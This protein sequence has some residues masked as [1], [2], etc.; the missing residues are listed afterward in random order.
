MLIWMWRK[1][2]LVDS[3][4]E[5]ELVQPLWK[6]SVV[7]L[8][9]WKIEVHYYLAISH[10]GIY[11][12]KKMKSE[13]QRGICIPMFT[14]TLFTTAR[15]EKTNTASLTNMWNLKHWTHRNREWNDGCQ[16]LRGEGYG[17]MLV[18]GSI[19]CKVSKWPQLTGLCTWK[20]LWGG[21]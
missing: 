19:S 14:A 7:F 1:R 13:S 16:G 4:W 21:L 12:K 20:L 2:T 11:P 18:K 8:K 5:F 15:Q 6:K 17:E 10:L 9:I 3:W